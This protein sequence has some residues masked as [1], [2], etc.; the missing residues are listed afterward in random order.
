MMGKPFIEQLKASWKQIGII[1]LVIVYI[2][3]NIFHIGGDAFVLTLN[4]NLSDPLALWI[5]ILAFMSW[6]QLAPRGQNRIYWAGL[7]IGWALWTIAEFWWG[8]AALVRK[9]IPYPSGAD[10]FWAAGFIPLY[11]A[12]LVRFRTLPR[13]IS[14]LQRAGIWG[15]ILAT[16]ASTIFFVLIPMIRANRPVVALENVLNITYPIMDMLLLILVLRILFIYQQGMYGRAWGWLSAGFVV[17]AISNLVFSYATTNNLFYPNGHATLLS[18]IGIDVPYNLS[19]L[20]WLI[21]LFIVRDV[22]INHRI[23]QDVDTHPLLK[24]VPNTHILVFTKA[25]D[26]VINVSRNF[27]IAFSLETANGKTIQQTLGIASDEADSILQV[28]KADNIL[29]ERQIVV[30][31]RWGQREAWISGIT[32]QDPSRT[33]SG[34]ILL[35]RM[36]TEDYALDELLTAYQRGVMNSLLTLTGTRE[37]DEEEIKE[38]LLNYYLAFLKRFYNRIIAEGG[39]IMADGFLTEMK[40]VARQHGWPIL[41]QPRTLLDISVLSLSTT[42]VALPIIFETARHFV[43]RITDEETADL[44]VQNVRSHFEEPVLRSVSHFEK[45]NI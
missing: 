9:D 41:F 39:G 16:L 8:I 2:A 37:K 23:I 4:N 32:T 18:T 10:F 25:D 14:S 20:C 3:I 34:I 43:I 6:R 36:F 24:L 26:T 1:C 11:I 40:S 13:K 31:S 12:I 22:Q 44:I 21:G 45:A 7:T 5:T 29:K 42:R 27:T 15:S 28:L 33:Y 30:S 17:Q 19:Y 38:L 35:I